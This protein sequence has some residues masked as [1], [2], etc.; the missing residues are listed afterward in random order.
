MT[1][2][3]KVLELSANWVYYLGAACIAVG[4]VY[5][6][7]S[8][9]KLGFLGTFLA[10]YF[11]FLKDAPCSGFPFSQYVSNPMYMG[12]TLSFAG[13]ALMASSA[14]G[15]ILTLWVYVVYRIALALE[16]TFTNY[17]YAQRELARAAGKTRK[18]SSRAVASSPSPS[19][20][21]S[22]SRSPRSKRK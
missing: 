21:R 8:F 15:L 6:L 5:V 1:T 4:Q 13:S 9:W 22:R 14:A 7:T 2:Q 12:A 16:E 10:D 3:P 18:S 19:K 20:S 17:I 11:G